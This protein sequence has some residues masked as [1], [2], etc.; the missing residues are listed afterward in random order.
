MEAYVGQEYAEPAGFPQL[1]EL[2]ILGK[3]VLKYN[4]CEL[5]E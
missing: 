3:M 4:S 5:W 1:P 2:R